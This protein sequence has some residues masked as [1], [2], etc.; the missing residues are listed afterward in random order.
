MKFGLHSI[1]LAAAVVLFVLSW[2]SDDNSGNLLTLGLA[3]FAGAFLATAIG[4]GDRSFGG[5]SRNDTT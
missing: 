5:S 3:C 1:L 2:V 4:L